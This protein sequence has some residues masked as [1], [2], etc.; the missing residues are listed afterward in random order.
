MTSDSIPPLPPGAL[1]K[2]GRFGRTYWA[3]GDSAQQV[4]ALDESPTAEITLTPASS[5]IDNSATTGGSEPRGFDCRVLPICVFSLYSLYFF[6]TSWPI[7]GGSSPVV[8]W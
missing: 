4:S 2:K 8:H 6:P 7:T 5:S 3:S 1:P